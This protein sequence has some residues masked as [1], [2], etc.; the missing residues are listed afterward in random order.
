MPN[1]SDLN[2]A[3][4][5]ELNRIASENGGLLQ[6]CA[7]VDAA[8]EPASILH[9]RF[10]WDDSEAAEQYRLWQARQLIRCS[11]VIEP[12]TETTV[13]AFV[14]LSQDRAQGGGGY[15]Q[16]VRVLA[17]ASGRDSLLADAL[18]ELEVFQRKYAALTELAEV[19]AAARTIIRR[20][21]AG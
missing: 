18:A 4:V 2:S 10:T 1:E 20:R 21:Q 11:V 17:N 6:P 8:R 3:V 13:R 5:A 9:D 19:F 14:S 15:R 7:V 16:T 12:R